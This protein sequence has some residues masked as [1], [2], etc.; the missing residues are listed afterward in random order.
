[1]LDVVDGC[2]VFVVS[3]EG[4]VGYG[5]CSG[6]GFKCRD[7]SCI[8]FRGIVI[9]DKVLDCVSDKC[10]GLYFDLFLVSEGYFVGRICVYLMCL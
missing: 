9:F 3:V 8:V 2:L 6:D 5:N 10:F 1:M 4:S 7:K